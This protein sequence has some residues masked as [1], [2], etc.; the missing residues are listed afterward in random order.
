VILNT[1]FLKKLDNSFLKVPLLSNDFKFHQDVLNARVS[2]KHIF[3]PGLSVSAG[4]AVEQTNIYFELQQNQT[5]FN[6]YV[7]LLP[8]ANFNRSW[9]NKTNLTFSYRRTI[10]RPGINELN[11]AIDYSDPY[12]L[13]FGNP[14]LLP[15]LS[16]TF[17]V[18]AGKTKEKFFFNFGV[19]YNLVEDIFS[20]IRTLQSDG[21]TIVTWDN[22]SNRQ[23]YEIS[24]WSGLTFSKKLRANFSSSYIY[25]QYGT[26]DKTVRKFRDGGSF[27]SNLNANYTPKDVWTFTGNFTF[28]RFAN[29]QGT[30]RSN[31]NMNIGIQRKILKKKFIITFN[32]VDPFVQ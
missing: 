1:E 28:N 5:V 26:F 15:T 3:K 9:K 7:N 23:E 4:A 8:F 13:R 10:R 22:V 11:P 31:V 21:K 14:E 27:T 16:H 12:N 17:D 18:V 30:V 24:H 32:A 20:Q 19:G 25:N 29:P 2:A 6:R